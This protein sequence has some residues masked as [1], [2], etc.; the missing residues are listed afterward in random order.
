MGVCMYECVVN[1]DDKQR[2]LVGQLNGLTSLPQPVE[3]EDYYWP[4][5]LH[6]GQDT[7]FRLLFPYP[8]DI[9]TQS[10][11]IFDSTAKS[12]EHSL[13]S[14]IPSIVIDK[15]RRLGWEIALA[16]Y[17]WSKTARRRRCRGR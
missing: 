5:V 15:S 6:S 10:Y 2:S 7:L 3:G 11:H 4:L 17:N 8:Q 13:K 9:Y 14:I 16:I 1:A 12:W